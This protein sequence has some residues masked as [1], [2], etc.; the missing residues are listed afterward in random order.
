M[1]IKCGMVV[2]SGGVILGKC[3][4]GGSKRTLEVFIMKNGDAI[5]M[6]NVAWTKRDIEAMQKD[7]ENIPNEEE[8]ISGID[9]DGK[10][11]V[12]KMQKQVPNTYAVFRVHALNAVVAVND[13]MDLLK[14][15]AYWTTIYRITFRFMERPDNSNCQN[16]DIVMDGE[17]SANTISEMD[18]VR[19]MKRVLASALRLPKE[20]NRQLFRKLDDNSFS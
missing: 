3:I 19:Y 20:S 13:R 18:S 5:Q 2:N 12:K 4:A 14:N 17:C 6:R 1:Q 11:V 9:D 10:R 7:E 15:Q 16:R 8:K